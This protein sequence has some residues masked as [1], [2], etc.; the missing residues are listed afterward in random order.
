MEVL[1]L[2]GFFFFQIVCENGTYGEECNN[3]CGQCRDEEYCYHTN[4]TCPSGC[5]SGYLDDICKTGNELVCFII[6]HLYVL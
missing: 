6:A 5:N 2:A 4:G 1:I 3:T